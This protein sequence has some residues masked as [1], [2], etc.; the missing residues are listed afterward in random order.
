MQ[1]AQGWADLTADFWSS[2]EGSAL[3]SFLEVRR[4]QGATVYPPQPLRA[5]QLTAPDRVRVVVLGQDPYHGPGQAEGLAFSVAPGVKPPP[6]LRNI[7]QELQRDLGLP[8]PADGSLVRWAQQGV[9][10]LNTCLTVED[11]QPA[12]HAKQGWEALTDRVIERCSATGQPK[13]FLLWG[14][15]AQKKA[16]LIDAGRHLLL[17]ANHPS[18]LS[19]RRGPL[20]FIG[21]GHFGQT[22][23]WLVRQGFPTI[24]W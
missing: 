14:A 6:S 2:R 18:P 3:Q 12:S 23:A 13:A 19:A 21:C 7:F 9:L 11:G 15:H 22:N 4:A 1:D 10:L 5:L 17:F 24:S 8:A 16:A 20:P